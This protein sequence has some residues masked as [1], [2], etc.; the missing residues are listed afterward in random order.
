MTLELPS[1]EAWAAACAADGEF[2]IAARHWN[3]GLRLGI[4]DRE[5]A[6]TVTAGAPSGQS[7]RRRRRSTTAPAIANGTR[8][9]YMTVPRSCHA[10]GRPSSDSK[11]ICW[12]GA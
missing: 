2:R 12:C 3:G 5:L 8:I 10:R 4:G 1:E 9:Q 7:K 6:I 11:S